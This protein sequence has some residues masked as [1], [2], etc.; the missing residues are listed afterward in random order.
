MAMREPGVARGGSGQRT[1]LAVVAAALWSGASESFRNEVLLPSI[2]RD[3]FAGLGLTFPAEPLNAAVWVAWSFVFAGVTFAV[4][5]R[6]GLTATTAIVWVT[7]FPMMWQV[8]WN[9]AVLP[10]G[11]L[12]VAVPLSLVEALGMAWVCARL[13]PVGRV[14]VGSAHAVT[15]R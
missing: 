5:R 9:L 10:L 11:V 2:W 13:A 8:T 3:H 4:S 6:F 14:A 12:P 15:L 1:L 7:A